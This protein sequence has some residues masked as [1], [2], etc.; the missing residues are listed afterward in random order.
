[1]WS[2]T[3]SEPS[4]RYR[5]ADCLKADA[6][7]ALEGLRVIPEVGRN[8]PK[9]TSNQCPNLLGLYCRAA[10]RLRLVRH[11]PLSRVAEMDVL[12]GRRYPASL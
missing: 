4:K 6:A 7:R 9:V 12:P 3:V 2:E 8:R 11:S 5:D 1:M 10:E